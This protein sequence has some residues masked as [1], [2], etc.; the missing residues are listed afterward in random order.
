MRTGVQEG[1]LQAAV[2]QAFEKPLAVI[3]RTQ[4]LVGER[5]SR[6]LERVD[7][8]HQGLQSFQLAIVFG[9]D[10]LG[11][12]CLDHLRR[13]F[14]A[15]NHSIVAEGAKATADHRS[16]GGGGQADRVS[17]RLG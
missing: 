10:D 14:P 17:S 9:A 15:G 7:R 13:G 6:R 1:V 5:L 3:Q 16:L 12:E 8:R 11:E 4:L 2:A